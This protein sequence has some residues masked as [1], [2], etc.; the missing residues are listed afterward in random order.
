[1]KRVLP[2]TVTG[3]FGLLAVVFFFTLTTMSKSHAGGPHEAVACLG[4]H[5]IHYAVGEKIFGVKNTSVQNPRTKTGLDGMAAQLCLGCHNLGQFGGAGIRP[6]H[7]HTT[8]P[9]G[10]VPNP[11]IARVPA[12][13]LRKGVLDCVSC[14]EPHPSNNSPLYLRVDISPEKKKYDEKRQLYQEQPAKIQKFCTVCHPNKADLELNKIDDTK[15]E[16]VSAMDE[17][18]PGKHVFPLNEVITNNITPYYITPLGKY[19]ENTIQN[20]GTFY[21]NKYEFVFSPTV[22][23]VKMFEDIKKAEGYQNTSVT[24]K[25]EMPPIDKAPMLPGKT[26]EKDVGY[27]KSAAPAEDKE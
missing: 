9:I 7:L 6:I 12:N 18:V 3:I 1:M 13:L 23:A 22:D 14:H 25:Q 20:K 2:Y 21:R 4:C 26:K 8:H 5:S 19:P 27:N 16:I 10:I 15:R 11:K 17:R 24:D